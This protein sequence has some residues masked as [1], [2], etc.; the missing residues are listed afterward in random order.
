M[1]QIDK[2]KFR[3][4][5]G[6]NIL[7]NNKKCKILAYYFMESFNNYRPTYGYT[8]KIGKGGHN[9]AYYSYDATAIIFHLMKRN[10]GLIQ[11]NG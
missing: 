1:P 4:K 11:R 10:V 9:G 6:D 8:L 5:I 2:S 7:Y 3:F